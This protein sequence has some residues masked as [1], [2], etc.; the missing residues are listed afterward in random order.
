MP[1]WVMLYSKQ[2]SSSTYH[3]S[4]E[5]GLV[6]LF[7]IWLACVHVYATSCLQVLPGVQ[8]VSGLGSVFEGSARIPELVRIF[9][10]SMRCKP[11]RCVLVKRRCLDVHALA[12]LQFHAQCGAE[13]SIIILRLIVTDDMTAL[14]FWGKSSDFQL[15]INDDCVKLIEEPVMCRP[16]RR[17]MCEQDS[18][19]HAAK[20][21]CVYNSVDTWEAP[22]LIVASVSLQ[23]RGSRCHLLLHA[24]RI[25][26]K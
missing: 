3:V 20:R 23:A 8:H 2:Q 18:A 26:L 16:V 6:F 7:T 10:S 11:V 22:E 4:A 24:N 13:M 14:R 1:V 5:D 15:L 17:L 19:A 21:I 12:L 9:L 25:P